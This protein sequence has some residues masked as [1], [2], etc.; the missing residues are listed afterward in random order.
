MK[1]DFTLIF[2]E[3][4]YA[5]LVRTSERL[6]GKPIGKTIV[7][8]KQVGISMIHLEKEL[9]LSIILRNKDGNE[10]LFTVDDPGKATAIVPPEPPTGPKKPRA[11]GNVLHLDFGKK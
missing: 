4:D 6:G 10:W 9:G 11:E 1:R 8:S 7:H 5:E 3:E 2:D